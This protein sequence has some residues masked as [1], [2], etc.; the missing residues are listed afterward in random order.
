[1]DED[2]AYPTVGIEPDEML[3]AFMQEKFFVSQAI[4]LIPVCV[5]GQRRMS[6]VTDGYNVRCAI[7]G[8]K[9]NASTYRKKRKQWDDMSFMCFFCMQ[10]YD[11]V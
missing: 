3:K 5:V 7:Y 6:S 9:Y 11:V 1:M 2:G 10:Y 4:W 8:P